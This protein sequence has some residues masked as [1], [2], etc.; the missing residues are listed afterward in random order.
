MVMR[1]VERVRH[2][3]IRELEGK[4]GIRI[5]GGGGSISIVGQW[6]RVPADFVLM[7][8]GIYIVGRYFE[9]PQI[10]V[11]FLSPRISLFVMRPPRCPHVSRI[12]PQSY[13]PI[14]EI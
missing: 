5:G 12:S 3:R 14:A 13:V 6:W 11:P 10:S 1:A 9:R 7:V 4:T 8:P 2:D